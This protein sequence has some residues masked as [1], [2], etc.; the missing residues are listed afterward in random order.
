M[1]YVLG[2]SGRNTSV[3]NIVHTSTPNK[4]PCSSGIAS[5]N[6]RS[7]ASQ[8]HQPN[9]SRST[10]MLSQQPTNVNKNIVTETKDKNR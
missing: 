7:P 4:S 8:Q 2:C 9:T 3:V 1:L 6:A 10:P 5:A